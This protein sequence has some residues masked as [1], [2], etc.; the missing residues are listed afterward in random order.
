MNIRNNPERGASAVEMAMVAPFL[1]LVLL[2]IIEFG[3]VFGQF[4]EIRHAT[5]EGARYAAVSNPDLDGGGIGNSDVIA[6]VC[7]S[8]NL[9]GATVEINASFAGT[10]SI[11]DQA[12]IEVIVDIDSLSG[13]PI[14]SSFVPDSLSNVATFRLEQDAKWNTIADTDAC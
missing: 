1:L 4:N 5:R 8:L 10:G 9:S 12:E 2:G 7:D 11:G 13:A 6:A 3:F 14:I